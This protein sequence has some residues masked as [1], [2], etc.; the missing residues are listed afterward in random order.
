M[1]AQSHESANQVV[2]CLF[3]IFSLAIFLIYLINSLYLVGNSDNFHLKYILVIFP[4]TTIPI[5]IQ[6]TAQTQDGPLSLKLMVFLKILID[7]HLNS[8]L[9]CTVN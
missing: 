6:I 8:I 7:T 5:D 9:G 1:K 2:L 3:F 4:N